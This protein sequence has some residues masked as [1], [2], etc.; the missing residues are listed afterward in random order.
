MPEPMHKKHRSKQ[1]YET[2]DDFLT[3]VKRRLGIKDF[4]FDF[5]ATAHNNKAKRGRFW[6]AEDDSLW[7]EPHEW[8]DACDDCWGWLNPP[9]TNIGPWTL[10]CAQAKIEGA[11]IAMLVPA[12]VGSNWF[13]DYVYGDARVLFLNGRLT[14]VGSTDCYPKDCLLLLW[15]SD[16]EDGFEIWSW[17]K[18]GERR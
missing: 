13:R 3:A 2:P 7:K 14:F 9:Y 10:A 11:R 15:D 12:G 8:V 5:A 16:L 1:D 4:A 17:N 18:E 6:D